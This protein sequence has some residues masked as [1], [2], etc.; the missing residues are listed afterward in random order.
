MAI[1]GCSITVEERMRLATRAVA[2]GYLSRCD[3]KS[4][5]R[6]LVH[7]AIEEALCGDQPVEVWTTLLGQVAWI[8]T[9]AGMFR[10]VLDSV[11]IDRHDQCIQETWFAVVEHETTRFLTEKGVES[12]PQK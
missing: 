10:H 1:I 4:R 3:D 5:V 7:N 2:A 8:V 11:G 6:A 9:P 12:E